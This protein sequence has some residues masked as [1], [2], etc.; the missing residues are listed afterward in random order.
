MESSYFPTNFSHISI[1]LRASVNE[2]VVQD[3]VLFLI[4]S[5]KAL[6]CWKNPGFMYWSTDYR[7]IRL[8]NFG[9]CFLIGFESVGSLILIP[10]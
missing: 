7:F 2:A 6:H 8:T 9:T 3:W 1:D 4:N 5:K 10:L